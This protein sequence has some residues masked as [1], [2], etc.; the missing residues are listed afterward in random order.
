M[1]GSLQPGYSRT[2]MCWPVQLPR[3]ATITRAVGP[4]QGWATGS[5]NCDVAQLD[6]PTPEPEGE[7]VDGQLDAGLAR[8]R[9]TRSRMRRCP[10]SVPINHATPP[11][12]SSSTARSVTTPARRTR[13]ALERRGHGASMGSTI[14]LM[15]P[16][17]PAHPLRVESRERENTCLHPPG[18]SEG[19]PVF[20][21]VLRPESV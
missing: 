10:A 6:P 11:A 19:H 17:T 18:V 9:V 2:R 14:A 12:T 20:P 3:S 16:P 5:S 8:R 15:I 7:T 21:A 13:R 1:T 4:E